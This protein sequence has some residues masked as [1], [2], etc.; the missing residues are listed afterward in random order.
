MYRSTCN[1]N[2]IQYYNNAMS[3]SIIHRPICIT[4]L[5][6]DIRRPN[7]WPS[8]VQLT[9]PCSLVGLHQS[10]RPT[11]YE[12]LGQP[13]AVKIGPNVKLGTRA[14]ARARA[15]PG[16]QTG[17]RARARSGQKFKHLP[18][19]G[20]GPVRNSNIYPGTGTVR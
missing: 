19:H 5:P 7:I 4:I 16:V 1:S 18:G 10:R 13:D 6:K 20:H 14:Q 3:K 8:N 17:T 11:P 9:R 15:G 12:S 2:I